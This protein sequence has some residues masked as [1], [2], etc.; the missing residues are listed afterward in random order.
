[1]RVPITR[2]AVITEDDELPALEQEEVLPNLKHQ[3]LFEYSA[4]KKGQVHIL[5]PY[6]AY[7]LKWKSDDLLV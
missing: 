3:P 7:A 1:V 5:E 4:Q 6:L 2:P